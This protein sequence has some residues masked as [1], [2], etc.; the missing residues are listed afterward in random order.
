MQAGTNAVQK[1][2]HWALHP[3]P[4]D[5]RPGWGCERSLDMR[6]KP[7]DVSYCGVA[8]AAAVMRGWP[9]RR[10]PPPSGMSLADWRDEVALQEAMQ[11]SLALEASK[12][13]L[14][15]MPSEDLIQVPAARQPPDAS[16]VRMPMCMCVYANYCGVARGSN[17]HM[18]VEILYMF[19][20]Y[21][22]CGTYLDCTC[23]HVCMYVKLILL[24]ILNMSYGRSLV[25]TPPHIFQ[26]PFRLGLPSCQ[27]PNG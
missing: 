14:Y 21:L 1:L 15:G 25:I 9:A 13:E 26:R 8:G 16:N 11:L 19:V 10:G 7:M 5:V 12:R 4:F 20:T 27:S 6:F 23:M 3:A 24:S 18:F 17:I 22:E 2:L